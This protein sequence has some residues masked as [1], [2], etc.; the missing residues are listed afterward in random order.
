MAQ[1]PELLEADDGLVL[2]RWTVDDA[3]AL[4]ELIADNL[5]HL[6]PYMPWIA[7]EPKA[8]EQRA[9][10][11]AEWERQWRAG[12]DVIFG[13]WLDGRLAGSCGLHDRIGP[14]GREIGYW[15]D[16]HHVRQ[17]LAQRSS[18]LLTSGAFAADPAVEVV[19][20]HHNETNWRSRRVPAALGYTEVGVIELTRDLAPAEG[21]IEHVWRVTRAEWAALGR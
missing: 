20:I 7:E 9:E 16:R 15:V 14:T 1:L 11:I 19:E 17:G 2:R 3:V 18:M 10:L 8:V 4:G 13:M 21:R 5:E 6:R 12:T